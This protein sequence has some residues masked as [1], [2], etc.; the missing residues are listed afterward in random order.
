VLG[1]TARDQNII[2]DNKINVRS[3]HYNRTNNERNEMPNYLIRATKT[4]EYEI[5]VRDVENEQAALATLDDWIS[6][7]FD[8]YA[9]TASWDFEVEE[10]E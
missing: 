2:Y 5:Y 7:D 3:S 6:N 10:D 1:G 8:S 9:T 4:S